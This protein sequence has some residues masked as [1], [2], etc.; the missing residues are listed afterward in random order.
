MTF[1]HIYLKEIIKIQDYFLLRKI[2]SK[3]PKF[4]IYEQYIFKQIYF[5]KKFQIIF[6]KE[7]F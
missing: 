3:I 2:F 7:V 4:I 5:K 1:V 6:E